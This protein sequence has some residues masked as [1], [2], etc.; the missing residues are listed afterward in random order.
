[1]DTLNLDALNT[2]FAVMSFVIGAMVG[3]FLN[4]CV[5]RL[6]QG[7]SVVKPRSRCPK[8]EAPIA[9]YDN[10]PLLSWL[11]LGAKCRNCSN[12]ISWQYPLV[13]AL[14]GTLFLLVYLKFGMTLASPVYMLLVASLVLVTFIDLTDW[15]IPNEVTF[16]GMPLGIALAVVAMLYPASG[17][18]LDKP[19]MS[20]IGLLVGGGVLYGLDM[21]SLLLL[22]KRGMGFGDV[23][24]LAM[25]GAFFGPWG[26]LLTM[27][28]ASFFG[29]AI[30]LTL[31]V[32]GRATGEKEATEAS[33][34]T[35]DEEDEDAMT[36]GG[37][38]LPFGPYIV[39]GGLIYLFFGPEIIERYLAYL[40]VQ[41]PI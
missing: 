36:P 30:G 35:D 11:I 2:L 5:H 39:L 29:S 1:M 28:I 13:E 38:Y 27:V 3:S 10:I 41:G 31:I 33:E 26:V 21:L 7:L 24:L 14:T 8:C 20:M 12:P 23:K 37:H 19:I 32:L 9:S 15:T 40:Q 22:K 6:P 4:V 17:L 34:E 25:L 16:P 18:L